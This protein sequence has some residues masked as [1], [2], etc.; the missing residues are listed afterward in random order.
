VSSAIR[1]SRLP[2]GAAALA[3]FAVLALATAPADAADQAPVF[4]TNPTIAGQAVVGR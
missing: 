1:Q 4:T 3:I 2:Q